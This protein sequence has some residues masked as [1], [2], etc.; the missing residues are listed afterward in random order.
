M[1]HEV[2]ST[3]QQVSIFI[4][5]YYNRNV[6]NTSV[7]LYAN[8][9]YGILHNNK[10]MSKGGSGIITASRQGA[11]EYSSISRTTD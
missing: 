3:I 10:K 6:S 11:K 7:V 4:N 1:I 2:G 5:N 9:V 8:A